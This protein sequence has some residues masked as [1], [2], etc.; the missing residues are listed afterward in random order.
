[1]KSSPRRS[2]AHELPTEQASQQVPQGLPVSGSAMGPDMN[3]NESLAVFQRRLAADPNDAMAWG[4]TGWTLRRL[5]RYHEAVEAYQRCLQLMPNLAQPHFEIGGTY[6]ELGR[7]REAQEHL[8]K[9]LELDGTRSD[10]HLGL[11]MV[12]GDFGRYEE[13]YERLD[14]AWRLSPGN[15][16]VASA[17]ATLLLNEGRSDEAWACVEPLVNQGGSPPNLL[18]VLSRIVKRRGPADQEKALV[19]VYQGLSAPPDNTARV[20][21]H[22]CAGELL[23]L[24]GRYD[25]AFF[26]FAS[27]NRLKN[28]RF[29][30]RV[31]VGQ[32]D[33]LIQFLT[34]DR[35]KRL[36]RS[37]HGE[38]TPIF[39]V[40]MMRSGTSLVEQILDTH[41]QALGGG[42]LSY[43]GEVADKL[44]GTLYSVQPYPHCLDALT[45]TAADIAS[46]LYLDRLKALAPDT[47]TTRIIDKMMTNF[48][49][50]GLIQLLFP[51]A[52]V[53]H[54]VRDPLD[55][56][57]SC[58]MQ[59]FASDLPF[60]YRMDH[61]ALFYRQYQRLMK[62]WREVLEMP[63]LEVRYEALVQQ[64]E[65][66]VRRV[67]EAAG[68]PWHAEC[69]NFH[70]NRRV[71]HTAS[72][73]QVRRPIY[74]TSVGRWRNYEK[75]LGPLRQALGV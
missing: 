9:A 57:L 37:T 8:T 46:R 6:R 36:P 71:V 50:L 49:H 14:A 13:A 4:G 32:V 73:E 26:H 22:F 39:I 35:L 27:G 19:Q 75:H 72:N 38:R 44:P 58:Y 28:A 45:P 1:M 15:P 18:R 54:T 67:L 47:G 62:H 7:M 31:V 55:T 56:C 43:L 69:L 16:E 70:K 53:I 41:P 3:P 25:E 2:V 74:R 33:G 5:G 24:L 20:M 64:P 59:N 21:L 17:R 34:K 51:A 68:L 42:E 30:G 66:V 10:H 12:A 63:V 40:G 48:F 61:L 60:T 11:G 23:D 52:T 65:P 29:D